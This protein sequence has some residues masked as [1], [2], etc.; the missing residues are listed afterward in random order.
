[1]VQLQAM[2]ASVTASSAATGA[3]CLGV[4][5]HLCIRPIEIDSWTP[6]LIK[7]CLAAITLLTVAQ[8]KFAAAERSS[9][10]AF[11]GA[12]W[13]GFRFDIG[14]FISIVT[15]RLFFHRLRVFPGPVGA[16]ISKFWAMKQA[17]KD[18]KWNVKVQEMHKV[19]GDFVRIG[20]LSTT[21][22]GV[23]HAGQSSHCDIGP[24][25][26]SIN[27]PSAIQALYGPPS[28]LLKAPWYAQLSSNP[29]ECSVNATR[30]VDDHRRRRR[31]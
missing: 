1:M 3:A 21:A 15:Y 23:L 2:L 20:E 24:R 22:L 14:A 4:A 29:A 16:G 6:A 26:I 27:R 11:L 7:A 12:S 10:S 5:F 30:D 13:M 8:W 25:E 9:L 19:Y 28:V 18:I 17:A 31:A